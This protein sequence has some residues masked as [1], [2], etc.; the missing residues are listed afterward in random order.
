MRTDGMVSMRKCKMSTKRMSRDRLMTGR[1]N[2]EVFQTTNRRLEKPGEGRG[3]SSTAPLAINVRVTSSR[4]APWMEVGAYEG[5]GMG[6]VDRGGGRRKG[7]RYP[8]RR[9]STTHGSAPLSL[10]AS[11]WRDR[12]PPDRVR[13]GDGCH[14]RKPEGVE[15]GADP[16]PPVKRMQPPE[17][18]EDAEHFPDRCAGR[19]GR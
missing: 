13:Q 19:G 9:T 8:S 11:Q 10:Q 5:K 4:A 14:F 16:L 18:K 12:Q 2:P 6:S 17:R 15:E 7:K 1:H 3:A